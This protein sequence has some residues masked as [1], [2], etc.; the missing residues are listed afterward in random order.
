MQLLFNWNQQPVLARIQ[1]WASPHQK[2]LLAPGDQG[3]GGQ[4]THP[5]VMTPRGS[6]VCTWEL[7]WLRKQNFHSL[8]RKRGIYRSRGP[9][10]RNGVAHAECLSLAQLMS[11]NVW[12][13]QKLSWKE[14]KE[15]LR[16]F[17][18]FF[19]NMPGQNVLSFPKGNNCRNGFSCLL[20]LR[21][22]ISILKRNHRFR[23]SFHQAI[24]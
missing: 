15:S 5:Q 2:C 1:S 10:N 8:S 7:C 13:N 22:M 20:L 6:S 23:F 12:I 11:A 4:V 24:I 3:E 21:G 14:T 19:I 17:L 18:V 16:K 9:V